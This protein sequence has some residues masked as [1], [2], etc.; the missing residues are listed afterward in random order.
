MVLLLS[1]S[2]QANTVPG[3]S[4]NSGV[5]PVL[6]F[7]VE[8]PRDAEG[9]QPV[10]PEGTIIHRSK[11]LVPA[12]GMP[13]ADIITGP[14]VVKLGEHWYGV[15]RTRQVFGQSS[16][17]LPCGHF[18]EVYVRSL[19]AGTGRSEIIVRCSVAVKV[20]IRGASQV[21]L[22]DPSGNVPLRDPY[23]LKPG[24]YLLIAVKHDPTATSTGGR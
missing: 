13:K 3:G 18:A 4:E 23:V 15:L 5:Q 16:G 12:V 22:G 21:F 20:D 6:E 11:E 19:G 8:W 14:N 17:D 24:D 1:C 10:V 9:D 7:V 2:P